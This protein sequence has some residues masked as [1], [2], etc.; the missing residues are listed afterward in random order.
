MV[1]LN[2]DHGLDLKWN[3]VECNRPITMYDTLIDYASANE[4]SVGIFRL[5][6]ILETKTIIYNQI[7]GVIAKE[8]SHKLFHVV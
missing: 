8:W 6:D 1:I 4:K 5:S 3:C 7:P 2:K